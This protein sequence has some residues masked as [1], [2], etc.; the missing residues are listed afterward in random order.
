MSAPPASGG[1]GLTFGAKGPFYIN[2]ILLETTD[3]LQMKKP[4]NLGKKTDSEKTYRTTVCEIWVKQKYNGRL[5]RPLCVP[6]VRFGM[7]GS[8]SM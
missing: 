3:A 4:R 6:C 5:C 2:L 7:V 1:R 8:S